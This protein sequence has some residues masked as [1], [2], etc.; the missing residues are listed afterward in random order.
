MASNGPYVTERTAQ[1][2]PDCAV[3]DRARDEVVWRPE[4]G[5]RVA[6]VDI[7]GRAKRRIPPH[8]CKRAAEVDPIADLS[9]PGDGA[10][11]KHGRGIRALAESSA[12]GGS[13]GARDNRGNKRRSEFCQSSLT[14]HDP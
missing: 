12:G 11:R 8:F 9:D 10:V 6:V 2:E 7:D 1:V 14:R 3:R 5:V 4:R 13:E